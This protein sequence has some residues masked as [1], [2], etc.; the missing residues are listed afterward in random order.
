MIGRRGGLLFGALIA[1][2]P[3][4]LPAFAQSH[5]GF[6]CNLYGPNYPCDPYLLYPPAQD[7]RLIVRA[8]TAVR[9]RRHDGRLNTLRELFAELRACWRPPALE[10]MYPGMELTVR[11]SFKRDG[12]I[13]GEP[14]FTYV[15][16]GAPA[17]QRERYRKAVVD[18][19]NEC[20]PLAFTAGL[21]G[22][23]AGRPLVIRYIDDRNNRQSRI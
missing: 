19:L 11:F 16:R 18:S 7:L 14:R 4:S 10:D 23:V 1:L 2:W 22:A 8:R 12:N 13:L 17:A 15:K 21:G 6:D 5:P 20:A 3:V 9:S